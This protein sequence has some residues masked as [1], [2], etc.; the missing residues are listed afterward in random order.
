MRIPTVNIPPTSFGY[1]VCLHIQYVVDVERA[2]TKNDP[3]HSSSFRAPA[4]AHADVC[5]SVEVTFHIGTPWHE[6]LKG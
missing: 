3:F 1:V 2:G 6:R 5:G 4:R